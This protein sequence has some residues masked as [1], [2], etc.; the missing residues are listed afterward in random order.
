M[1]ARELNQDGAGARLSIGA[2]ARATGISIETL[3]TWERRYGY[4]VPERKASGH[5]VYPIESVARLR[6]IAAALACGHRAR[7]V[8]TA[9]EAELGALLGTAPAAPRRELAAHTSE[10]PELL[11]AIER[12]DAGALTRP[13]LAEWA[14]LDPLDFLRHRVAPLIR[15]VGDRWERGT[16]EIRHEH[17]VSERLGDLLR[18]IRM[19][20]EERATGR[21]LVF[22]TLPGEAHGLGLQMAALLLASLGRRICYL[23]TEVPVAQIASLAHDLGAT[24]VGIS[25]SEAADRRVSRTRLTQ[26]RHALPGRTTVLVG[27]TGAP[28]G[29]DGMLVFRDLTALH[30]WAVQP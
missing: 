9:S 14:R 3:R 19:P 4:P 30:D 16:L 20:F 8:V 15:E 1:D 27:G 13:L 24:G 2:L 29:S 23:G 18:I 28:P 25:V 5:R 21:L 12:F 17:F 6:R 10:M 7:E 26:L 22:A 11:A